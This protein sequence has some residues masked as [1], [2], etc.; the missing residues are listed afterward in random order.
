[1]LQTLR[2]KILFYLVLI[3]LIGILI[4]S[5]FIQYGFE[6]SFNSYLDRSREKRLIELSRKLR[7]TTKKMV[8]LPV[9]R[10]MDCCMR[11]P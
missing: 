3:S 1:M 6:E 2:S 8:T 11:T 10:S 5:F 7:K 9:T 4:V